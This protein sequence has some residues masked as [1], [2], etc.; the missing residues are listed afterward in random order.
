MATTSGHR[1][2]ARSAVSIVEYALIG[3][4]LAVL[5]LYLPH[6][7]VGDD[8]HRFG[9]IERL[10]RDGELSDGK[11]SL[12]MPLVSLPLLE[13]GDAIQS[14]EWWAARFNVIVVALGIVV[15]LAL[16]RGR[17]DGRVLRRCVL[18]L[19]F[20]SLLTNRLRDYNAEV[21]TATLTTV[22]IALLATGR[23]RLLAWS[24]IVVGVVNTPAAFVALGLVAFVETLRARRLRYLLPVPAAAAAIMTEAWIRRGG[25]LVT[26][27]EGE[28]GFATILPYSGRPGF[29][30]PFVLGVLSILFS[31]GRGLLFFAPGL[32]LWLSSRTR[33]LAGTCWP[34]V[35]FLLVYL[36]GLVLV[37]AKWWAWYGGIAW[38]PRFFVFA[39]VPA[40][41]AIAVRL[42]RAGESALA[43]AATLLVLSCSAWVGLA[44]VIA[45]P[46]ALDICGENNYALE[47]LCWYVPE[48][49]SL[50]YPLR[51]VPEL[52]NATGL[53][54]AYCALVFA[55]LAAPLV[56]S[57]AR[58]AARLWPRAAWASGWRL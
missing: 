42:V 56:A 34:S 4:G 19:L 11:Y 39:A 2:S 51:D 44:G 45:D 24:A 31:F 6:G 41:L 16:L 15:V 25:P 29:S 37:Y 33:R 14:P 35:V 28:H 32:V 21:L 46:R 12:V 30:F 43:D 53:V 26:G 49:S 5:F 50:W 17:V 3:L 9:D 52:T 18:V 58:A 20:A 48:Y 10:R 7:L 57:L 47:S 27:Y 38:G 23:A 36:A 55:Y 13:L 22:G 8:L 1:S 54:A 40:S